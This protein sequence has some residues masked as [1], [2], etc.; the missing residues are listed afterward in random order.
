M[1]TSLFSAGGI[2]LAAIVGGFVGAWLSAHYA[3]RAMRLTR[4]Q[5]LYPEVLFASSKIYLFANAVIATPK[6]RLWL[7]WPDIWRQ[8]LLSLMSESIDLGLRTIAELVLV[9]DPS[10]K[11]VADLLSR[12][13][14]IQS[15][16]VSQLLARKRN[17]VALEEMNTII[18]ELR[19]VMKDDIASMEASR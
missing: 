6:W 12:L 15:E 5:N 11:R 1:S 9:D 8:Y 16:I 17:R 7:P 19:D 10:S 4:R 3:A 13:T 14:E 18:R 2:L